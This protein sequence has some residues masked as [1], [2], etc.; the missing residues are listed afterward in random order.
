M[1]VGGT[2]FCITPS[3]ITLSAPRM[4]CY[5]I[6]LQAKSARASGGRS[7]K[8]EMPMGDIVRLV[9]KSELERIRL[10]REARA[11]YDSIF[12]QSDVVGER[13]EGQFGQRT[14]PAG[15][16]LFSREET[17]GRQIQSRP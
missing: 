11:I 5:N 1:G 7:N 17:V 4:L 14:Q 13:P 10:I 6:T 9:L 16:S 15:E 12:P 2:K 8:V 3:N